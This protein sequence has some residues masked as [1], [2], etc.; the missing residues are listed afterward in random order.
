[1]ELL[2]IT[3]CCC[4][5][6]SRPGSNCATRERLVSAMAWDTSGVA[7][8]QQHS[9][10]RNEGDAICVELRT[11]G[12]VRHPGRRC[13]AR[14]AAF[15]TA[16]L[17][18]ALARIHRC[19]IRALLGSRRHRPRRARWLHELSPLCELHGAPSSTAARSEGATRCFPGTLAEVLSNSC[20][21]LPRSVRYLRCTHG[22]EPKISNV[23]YGQ[24]GE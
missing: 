20:T 1:M 16:A 19:T 9:R 13:A 15:E 12:A 5:F 3:L 17:S 2:R 18:R 21:H 23:V 8:P 4:D 11:L 10:L 24:N 22:S 6:F 7:H 14:R